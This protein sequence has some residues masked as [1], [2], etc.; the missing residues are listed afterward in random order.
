MIESLKLVFK[1]FKHTQV[2]GVIKHMIRKIIEQ[3]V[4]KHMERMLGYKCD[5]TKL[6]NK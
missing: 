1:I 2:V 6:H 3:L 4:I 5:Q